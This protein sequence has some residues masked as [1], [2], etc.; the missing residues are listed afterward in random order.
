MENNYHKLISFL[1][2]KAMVSF[3]KYQEKIKNNF[4]IFGLNMKKKKKKVEYN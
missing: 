3:K 2:T 4:L 1:F